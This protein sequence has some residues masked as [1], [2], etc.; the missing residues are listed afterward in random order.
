VA[1]PSTAPYSVAELAANPIA[2]QT[3]AGNMCNMPAMA[4]PQP[5]D[6]R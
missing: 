1:N 4:K 2:T 3:R 5:A 6:N